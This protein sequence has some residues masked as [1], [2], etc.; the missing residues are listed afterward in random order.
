MS[1]VTELRVWRGCTLISLDD[2]PSMRVR[3]V[4]FEKRPLEI[5]EEIDADAYLNQLAALQFADAYETALS[6][7]DFCARAAKELERS[8]LNKGYVPPAVEAVL[9]RLR[10]NRLIDDRRLATRIA[11]TNASK[12]VGVY[13]MKRKLRAKGIS[14]ED[15]SDALENFDEEQQRKAAQAAGEKLLK[16]YADLPSRERR[17]KLSQALARRGFPWDAVSAAVSALLSEDEWDS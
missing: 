5:G 4:H 7:L 10:E 14:D 6:S 12:P 8:L 17:A 1:M 9:D 11:E 16:R 2:A 3:T 13:A 15:A